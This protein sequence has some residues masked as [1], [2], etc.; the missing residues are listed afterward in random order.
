MIV[1]PCFFFSSC[2]PEKTKHNL[3][4]PS[5]GSFG[6][7]HGRGPILVLK[8]KDCMDVVH[9]SSTLDLPWDVL[10]SVHQNICPKGFVRRLHSFFN[11]V[12]RFSLSPHGTSQDLEFHFKRESMPSRLGINSRIT[13]FFWLVSTCPPKTRVLGYQVPLLRFFNQVLQHLFQIPFGV[14]HDPEVVGPR[15]A[16]YL[17]CL[18][19]F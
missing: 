8:G 17:M 3:S 2:V 12:M 6:S 10:I 13:P 9:Q 15:E 14:G 18:F 16:A 19:T 1:D 7:L 5:F 11:G 4:L